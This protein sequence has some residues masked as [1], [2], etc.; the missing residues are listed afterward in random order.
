MSKLQFGTGL[1]S[2][3]DTAQFARRAEALGYDVL[4]CG[5]HVMFHGPIGNTFVQL[6]VA[7]GATERI[8]LMS[9]IALLPLY[10]ATLAAKCWV[11]SRVTRSASRSV[12]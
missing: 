10:P 1:R 8:R 11:V 5:E 12:W 7:A 4:G 2:V 3:A 6:A 9:T